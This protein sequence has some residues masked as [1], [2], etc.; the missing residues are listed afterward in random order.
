M[1]RHNLKDSSNRNW[2]TVFV[3]VMLSLSLGIITTI[4]T[5]SPHLT[6]AQEQNDIKIGTFNYTQ[7]D[8]LGHADWLNTGNWSLKESPSV[9]LTFNAV[10]N[11]AKPDGSEAHQHR[12]N[13]LI[14]PY[15]PINRVNSTVIHGTTTL[16]MN[17]DTFISEVPTTITL[18]EKNISVYF[19]P[20]KTYNHFGNQSITGALTR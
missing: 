2:P 6:S 13:D 12:V 9:V 20:A 16:T 19:D 3:A 18:G 15:A 11:M 17:N 8:A 10:I 7:T 5:S 1:Q 14:I 4:S